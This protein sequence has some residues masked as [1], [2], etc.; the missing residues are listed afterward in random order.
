MKYEQIENY[1]DMSFKIISMVN[2]IHIHKYGIAK[3]K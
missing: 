1:S 3:Q 2:I